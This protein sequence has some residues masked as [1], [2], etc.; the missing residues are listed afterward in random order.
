MITSKGVNNSF[1]AYNVSL[2]TTLKFATV[3]NQ[4]LIFTLHM[5]TSSHTGC[6]LDETPLPPPQP[7]R[8]GTECW[9]VI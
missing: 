8:K 7:G 6:F 9:T 3:I 4:S 1:I 5:R 2:I